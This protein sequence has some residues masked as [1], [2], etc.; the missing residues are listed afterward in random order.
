MPGPYCY[1]YPRPQVTVDLVVFTL[2][3]RSLRVLP[4][5]PRARS[6]RRQVGDSRRVPRDGRARRGRRPARAPRGDRPRG[7]RADRPDRLLREAR[8]RPEGPD[9]HPGP[10]GGGPR[11]R[12]RGPRGRRRGRGGLVAARGAA[13]PGVRPR[14]DPGRGEGVADSRRRQWRART[15]HPPRVVR[16][17]RTSCALFDGLGLPARQ[18]DD[19]LERI[20]RRGKIH[21]RGSGAA[22]Q[23][24]G[25]VDE[26]APSIARPEPAGR[27]PRRFRRRMQSRRRRD[28]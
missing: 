26:R 19:W 24:A 2:V 14:G 10:C 23:L 25:M 28:V 6:V 17:P 12:G 16:R 3:E 5:P 18:A 22:S 4:D 20:D 9:D 13:R 11:R 7:P 15:A 27:S 21:R 1:D 8:P